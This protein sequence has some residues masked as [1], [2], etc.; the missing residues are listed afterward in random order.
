[1]ET[2]SLAIGI[3]AVASGALLVAAFAAL[4]LANRT[5]TRPVKNL[6]LIYVGADSC[7]P[8]EIW[9]RNQGTAFRDSPEFQRLIYREVK[10]PNLFDVLKDSNWPQELR[11]YRQAIGD[12][13]GVPLWL[14]IGDDEIVMQSSGL[15]QWQAVVL[16]KIQQLVHHSTH[17]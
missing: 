2:R 16:P 11:I 13:A 6:T 15:T 17:R 10:S 12:G 8:C 1:M 7:A 5:S 14:I 9:Q 3:V 4:A